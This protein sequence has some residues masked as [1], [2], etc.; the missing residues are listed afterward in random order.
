MVAP[1]EKL[2]WPPPEKKIRRSCSHACY[3]S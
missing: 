1:L 2:F 3:Q